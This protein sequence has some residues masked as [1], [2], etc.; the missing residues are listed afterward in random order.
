MSITTNGTVEGEM[1]LVSSLFPLTFRRNHLETKLQSIEVPSFYFLFFFRS[2]HSP[3]PYSQQQYHYDEIILDIW[4]NIY[5]YIFWNNF[6]LEINIFS[7]FTEQH[8][9]SSQ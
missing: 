3:R 2:I 9:T 5:K 7:F 6:N 1:K 8:D 4:N